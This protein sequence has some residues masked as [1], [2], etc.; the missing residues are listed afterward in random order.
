MSDLPIVAPGYET[1]EAP[2]REN[3]DGVLCNR[4]VLD[5]QTLRAAMDAAMRA[6][7]GLRFA[8]ILEPVLALVALGLMI[9]SIAARAGAAA[10]LLSAFLLGMLIY[11]YLQQFVLYPKKAVK[12]QLLRQAT[13]D[14]SLAPE[15]RLFFREENVANLRG[16]AEEPLHMPY[17]KI[18][19]VFADGRLIVIQTRSKNNIPLDR[20]GFSNG[21]EEDFWR[22]LR[23]KAPRAKLRR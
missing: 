15:N 16:E 14:G 2:E 3:L 10:I 21:T 13:G 19:R 11:F 8:G 17:E 22:I 9:W 6:N 18:K 20:E 1:E 12:N 4:C 5:E 7:P 23:Q